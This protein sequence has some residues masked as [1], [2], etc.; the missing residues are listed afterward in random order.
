MPAGRWAVG[1][2]ERWRTHCSSCCLATHLAPPL[3]RALLPAGYKLEVPEPPNCYSTAAAV[4]DY[5]LWFAQAAGHSKRQSVVELTL[6]VGGWL[7]FDQ[8]HP[9]NVGRN[10]A[11]LWEVHPVMRLEW[12]SPAGEWVS[13]DSLSPTKP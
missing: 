2:L 13:L 12:Q 5:H 11:T 7:M 6:R 9:E 4:K 1:L 8:M 10:R 3:R